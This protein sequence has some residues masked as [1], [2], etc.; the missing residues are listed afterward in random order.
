MK[1]LAI[2]DVIG[3]V[4]SEYLRA[5]LPAFKQ[6][7]KVDVVVCN[8]ENSSSTNAISPRSAQFLL[9]SGVDVVTTGNH[10]FRRKEIYDYLEEEPFVIRPANYEAGVPGVGVCVL[11]KGSFQVAVINLMGTAFLEP[12]RNPFFVV[13]ALLE[14][15]KEKYI[16]VDFHAEDTAEKIAMAHYL[17]GR[18]S[19]LFGTH[20]HVQTADARVFPQG[21]GYITDLGM[22]GPIHSC[23]GVEPELAIR[24]FRTNMPV[25]FTHAQ[26]PCKLCG[27]LFTMD[28]AGRTVEICPVQL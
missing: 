6:K 27:C 9:D 3:H 24:K 18:V 1:L 22:T 20:T 13:D 12:L 26:G 21:M 25:R 2:G 19:A 28:N 7:E 23:L 17:D 8:G 14:E 11:D 5:V 15:H 4:G 10:V 16:V